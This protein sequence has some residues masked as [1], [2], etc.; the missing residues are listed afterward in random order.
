[1]QTRTIYSVYKH[2][3]SNGKS[4]I[5]VS[6][7]L[8]KRK[9]QHINEAFNKNGK[10]YN[11]TFKRAIR[12]YG[13]NDIT[14]TI[15]FETPNEDTAYLAEVYFIAIFDTYLGNGYNDDKG[16]RGGK[17]MLGKNHSQSSINKISQSKQGSKVSAKTKKKMSNSHI[18]LKHTEESKKKISQSNKGKTKTKEHRMKLSKLRIGKKASLETKKK[19][20]TTHSSTWKIISPSGEEYVVEHLISFCKSHNLNVGCFRRSARQN[21]LYKGYYIKKL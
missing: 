19:M 12:K 20:S 13:F 14:T 16:G 10:A 11:F 7:N 1:M 8:I 2:T 3:F 18:G 21:K 6:G 4:Y 17:G 9:Q 15:L 5:G